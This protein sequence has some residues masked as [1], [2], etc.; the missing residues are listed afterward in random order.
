MTSAIGYIRV[1]TNEQDQTGL[2]L[3]AQRRKIGHMVTKADIE[4]VR[5]EIAA[6][7]YPHLSH[8][9]DRRRLPGCRNQRPD[10]ALTPRLITRTRRNPISGYRGLTMRNS[11]TTLDQ[12]N[13]MQ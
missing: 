2:S 8:D 12:T 13:P 6:V 3:D 10:T 4:A 11:Q 1:S 7:R 5:G 9:P